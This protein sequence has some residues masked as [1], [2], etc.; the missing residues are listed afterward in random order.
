MDLVPSK[1]A[2]YYICQGCQ[3]FYEQPL[4]R[5]VE[6]VHERSGNVNLL[7]K[8]QAGP[9]VPQKCTECG[10]AL[11]VSGTNP[12]Q[13]L[14]SCCGRSPARCGLVRYTIRASF[15]KCLSTWRVIKTDIA[16]LSA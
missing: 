9:P 3:S 4:G 8:T 2:M 6:K 15:Q 1:T 12:D 7:F 11:H 5:I 14:D 16:Q 10:S 13:G